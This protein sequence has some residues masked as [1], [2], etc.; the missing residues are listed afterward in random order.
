[1]RLDPTIRHTQEAKEVF[2]DTN[3]R[4]HYKVQYK[5]FKG[6]YIA[7]VSSE[8]PAALAGRPIRVLLMDEIDRFPISAGKEGDP[9]EIASART[10]TFC[11]R[12]KIL[13]SIPPVERTSRIH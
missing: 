10:R 3:D 5:A 6:G 9:V 13:T 8:V 4:K 12:N 11:N 1:M 7:L 2:A